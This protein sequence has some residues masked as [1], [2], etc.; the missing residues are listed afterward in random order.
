[1][2]IFKKKK[3]YFLESFSVLAEYSL[4]ALEE[5]AEGLKHFDNKNLEELKN[6]VHEVEHSAD[7]KKREIESHLQDE[8]IT[9]IDRE[10]I[11]VLLDRIDDLTDSID[12]ISYKLYIRNYES[13]PDNLNEFIDYS[14][15]CVKALLEG[16]KALDNTIDKKKLD[17]YIDKVLLIEETVDKLYEAN[18]RDLYLNKDKEQDLF[19]KEKLYSYFEY[20]TDKCRDCI[21]ELQIIIYKN[22]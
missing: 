10:D 16:L 11:F 9:P 4:K 1:M 19:M 22:L 13:I 21:K 2:A 15:D 18:V 12:E 8:F 20:V 5:L 17:P 6:K 3:D 7:V 14:L